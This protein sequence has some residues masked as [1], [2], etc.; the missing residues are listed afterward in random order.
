[1]V[2]INFKNEESIK[3][4]HIENDT[5]MGGVST[6][7]IGYL[8]EDSGVKGILFF[9]GDV[10]LKNDGG[11][12]QIL[13]ENQVLNL[14]KCIGLELKLKGDGKN[15]QLRFETNT[16][17]IGYSKSFSTTNDWGVIRLAFA[18]FKPDFH[19]EFIPNAPALDLE[20]IKN[21]GLLI[22]NNKEESFKL[23]VN[24]IKSY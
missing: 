23:L 2:L 24:E 12:A 1:M 7:K 15:Y 8:K 16:T 17:K 18:D 20:N 4:W 6:S 10:S 5:V 3:K 9:Q 21:I 22:G 14:T 19:G 13:Y 11:F